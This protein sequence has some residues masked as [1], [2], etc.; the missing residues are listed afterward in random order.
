MS[1]Y[2]Q[3]W[4]AIIL[5]TLLALVGSLFASVMSS[6]AYLN[7]QLRMKNEDNA[8]VLALSLAQKEL[9]PITLEL[10]VA[11]LFDNGHYASITI[12]DTS[13]KK[14]VE[15]IAPIEMTD[16]PVWFTRIFPI[17]SRAGQA[18]ISS[19]WKQLGSIS[20]VS[21]S[22]GAYQTLWNSTKE[23]A[24]ILSI[25]GLIA[26]YL[27]TLILRRLKAPLQAVIHQAKGMTER[28]FITT[29]VSKVPELR[30]LSLAMNSTVGLLKSIFAEEAERL[31]TLRS[32]ANCDQLTGLANRAH[33]LAQLQVTVEEEN[34]PPGSLILIKITGLADINK[35]IGR[36]QADALL[37]MVGAN[38]LNQQAQL[39]DGFA[40]RLNGTDFAL[41]F[42]EGDAAMLAQ[43][44]LTEIL[45]LF[46][47][48]HERVSI[49]IGYGSYEFGITSSVLLSQTDAAVASLEAKG[50]S[51]IFETAPL[52]I[53]HAPRSADEWSR[54]IAR[55][56][57]Q[58]WVKLAYFPVTNIEGGL[59]HRESA[60]R[61][62]FGGEWFP[63]GRFLPIAE[64]LG[65]TGKLDLVAVQLALEELN[66][67]LSQ[68]DIAV[69][70]SAQSIQDSEF[71]SQLRTL[72]LG[73]PAASKRLWLEIPENGVFN[74]LDAFRVFHKEI[75]QT[76]C[77]FGLE[78]FGKQF[79]KINLLHELRL[80]YIKLDGSFVR[81]LDINEANQEF[82]KGIAAICHRMG[83]Q[84]FAEGVNT[85]AERKSF[86]GLHADGLTGPE[87][88]RAFPLTEQH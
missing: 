54:L 48:V 17:T 50:D 46:S 88:G 18:Q 63:A 82:I 9:D 57:E 43:Q 53:E 16:T 4:L 29:P 35:A 68:Q 20:L 52:N 75:A 19:G 8:T 13:G 59:I 44:L 51:G 45:Q 31:E 30:Q 1:M 71:R 5:S 25:S 74:N 2:R 56:L 40:A 77:K 79:D 70:L 80:N 41:L 28:H 34:A 84:F 64:R 60:L 87:I 42:R 26:A 32:Q 3:L 15:R 85:N 10:V 33:F 38:L 49:F 76:G 69:N 78:H 55:A 67:T 83:L 39:L 11:S 37:K 21:Q 72:L 22:N 23:M 6:R 12:N 14:I 7:E 73:K 27:G 62:M 81:N 86:A 58:R 66:R 47:A 61:L 36:N 24:T 65:I